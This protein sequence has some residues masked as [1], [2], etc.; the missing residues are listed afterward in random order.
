MACRSCNVVRKCFR[1]A[2][3]GVSGVYFLASEIHRSSSIK[4]SIEKLREEARRRQKR[5]GSHRVLLTC[6]QALYGYGT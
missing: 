4:L 6:E 2:F 5:S 1:S 3:R